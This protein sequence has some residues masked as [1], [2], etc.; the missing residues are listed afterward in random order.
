VTGVPVLG[1]FLGAAHRHLD[2]PADWTS[3]AAPGRDIEEVTGSLLRFIT[4]TTRYVGDVIAVFDEVTGSS[5]SMRTAWPFAAADV[6]AALYGA[7]AALGLET[8]S[9]RPPADRLANGLA[10]RLDVASTSLAAGRD[11]LQ[12]HFAQGRWGQLYRSAWAPVIASPAVSAA[13]LADITSLAGQAASL[14]SAM[15]ESPG[16]SA[17]T[18]AAA[19]RLDVS[20][21]WL[22]QAADLTQAVRRR[23]PVPAADWELLYAIPATAL[24]TRDLGNGPQS[25]SEL[26]EAITITA[27]RAR[28]AA[29]LAGGV[30]GQSSAMSVT[31]WR[32]ISA[33]GGAAS[34]H[35][36]MLLD[37]LSGQAAQLGDAGLSFRLE[38]AARNA[39]ASHGSWMLSARRLGEVMTDVRWRVSRAAIEAADLALLT[40]R[41]AHASPDW[42]PSS[43]ASEPAR[44]AADLAPAAGDVLTVL[45]AVHQAADGLASLGQANQSQVHAA[46]GVRRFLVLGQSRQAAMAAAADSFVRPSGKH[47]L[48][49]LA[50]CDDALDAS[51]RTAG[52]IGE[53]AVAVEAPSRVLAAARDAVESRSRAR[54]ALADPDSRAADHGGRRAGRVA[55][56]RGRP[57]RTGESR[58]LPGPFEARLREIGVTG[59][60]FLRR[61]ASIDR[62]G[63]QVIVDAA[64][65]ILH[66]R[67]PTASPARIA[68]AAR[69][70]N[71]QA[72]QQSQSVRPPEQELEAEL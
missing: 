7:S 4:I 41:L 30:D 40:G 15:P 60:R 47:T 50:A 44:A 20:C 24:P 26:C 54:P 12:T 64:A 66:Q 16:Q 45:A 36:Q 21:H 2:G 32:R 22:A 67:S 51:A 55:R 14:A 34:R 19:S 39:K 11:L 5:D 61:A 46:A 13:L 43:V 56:P 68:G 53:I 52:S 29:W 10:R 38:L 28:R 63:Q 58:H 8:P 62:S 18:G 23:E 37:A 48:A 25:V 59:S 57:A 31:S 35:C 65:E 27:E 71:H 3:T 1:D 72:S 33:S 9:A 70:A 42:T 6:L 49:I 17:A 69:R